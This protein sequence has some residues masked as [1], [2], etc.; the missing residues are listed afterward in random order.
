MVKIVDSAYRC[1]N[2]DSSFRYAKARTG[3]QVPHHARAGRSVRRYSTWYIC[4]LT[5]IIFRGGCLDSCCIYFC[6]SYRYF[7]SEKICCSCSD[8]SRKSSRG[9]DRIT[10]R[11]GYCSSDSAKQLISRRSEIWAWNLH[12]SWCYGHLEERGAIGSCRTCSVD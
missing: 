9:V 3:T 11:C 2:C 7:I 6:W 10:F 4:D 8:C 5:F 12:C 1:C